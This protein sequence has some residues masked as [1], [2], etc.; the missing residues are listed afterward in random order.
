MQS[1]LEDAGFG[2]LD[3]GAEWKL[4][5]GGRY[6][7]VRN[8]SALAAFVVEGVPTTIPLH[9]RVLA[10]ADFR[11]GR[12]DTGFLPRLLGNFCDRI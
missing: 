10:D 8:G 11:A 9:R 6:Y 2:L 1:R 4:E 12:Y 5:P 3:E 7:V